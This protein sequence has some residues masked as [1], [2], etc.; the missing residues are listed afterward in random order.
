MQEIWT[1]G[2]DWDDVLPNNLSVKWKDWVLELKN[3][4]Y[5]TIPRCLRLPNPKTIEL[6][7]FSDACT[8]A[9]ASVAHSVCHYTNNTSNTSNCVKE[10]CVTFESG[11][12]SPSRAN[13]SCSVDSSNPEYPKRVIRRPNDLLDRLREHVLLGTKP[14]SRI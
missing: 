8:D 6:H 12:N 4:S 10:P 5:V 11:N 1:T 9:Y 3:L 2:L 14:E 7:L 13:G